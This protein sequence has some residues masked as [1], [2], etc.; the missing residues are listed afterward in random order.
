MYFACQ[1]CE[2][3]QFALARVLYV[4]VACFCSLISLPFS[5]N[6]K[7]MRW[8]KVSPL[9]L[10]MWRCLG[11]AAQNHQFSN[12]VSVDVPPVL[13]NFRLKRRSRIS[14]LIYCRRHILSETM[15]LYFNRWKSPDNEFRKSQFELKGIPTIVDYGTVSTFVL[16]MII[17]VGLEQFSIEICPSNHS[18]G[19]KL[20]RQS[21]EPIK[22]HLRNEIMYM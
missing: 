14:F 12:F 7:Y 6:G 22:T 8:Y 16:Q 4:P 18:A 5:G 17:F 1:L 21:C 15:V 11:V 19:H 9:T 10:S 2:N 13:R 20:Q 3:V